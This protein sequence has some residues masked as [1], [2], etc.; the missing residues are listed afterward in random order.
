MGCWLTNPVNLTYLTNLTVE[1]LNIAL[2][3]YLSIKSSQKPSQVTL[4]YVSKLALVVKFVN[5]YES[6]CK[7]PSLTCVNELAVKIMNICEWFEKIP[8]EV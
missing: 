8:S 7:I 6:K 3:D 4:R 2:H 1:I 5:I